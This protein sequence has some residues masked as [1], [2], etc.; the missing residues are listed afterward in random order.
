M[1]SNG[2][3]MSDDGKSGVTV[4]IDDDE[5][6]EIGADPSLGNVNNMYSDQYLMIV[7]IISL[8]LSFSWYDIGLCFIICLSSSTSHQH[9][10][11]L[12]SF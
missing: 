6:I 8:L 9:L 10:V 2:C 7:F 3:R 4:D 1:C 12:L 11:H 5:Y